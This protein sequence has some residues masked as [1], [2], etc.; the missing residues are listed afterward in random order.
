MSKLE[1]LT[2]N[3]AVAKGA[4]TA[5]CT[6]YSG[7]PITPSSEIA[8]EM[9]RLLPRVNGK[10]IQMEDEIAGMGAAIGASLTGAK[11]MTATS[12]PGFS[13]KQENLGFAIMTEIPVVIVNVMRGGPSTGMPTY[14]SQADVMQAKWGTHGDHEIIALCPS[15]VVESFEYTVK[16]FNLAE[17]YRTP[18]VLLIDE[19]IAHMSEKV[20][21]FNPS[22][23]RIKNRIKV[24][25]RP[26]KYKPYDTKFGDVPPLA[27]YGEGYRYHITG[28]THDQTGFPSMNAKIVRDLQERLIDKIQNKMKYFSYYEER[29]TE[30]AEVI[31]IAYGSVARSAMRAIKD[32]RKRGIK[33]GLYRPITI[34]PFNQKRI[35]RYA[36]K[37]N[38]FLVPEMN[39]GQLVHE[40]RSSL[41]GK[42]TK[43]HTLNK[44]D[45]ELITPSEILVKL[46][47]VMHV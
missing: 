29:M 19:I 28:L 13:L 3:E 1:L 45:G 43:I 27:P 39:M 26:E 23:Y 42:D 38:H 6:F 34:W 22:H 12:G 41:H 2:G 31:I 10:F 21:M 16:A 46:M 9:S 14:P 4:I 25:E 33:A 24:S 17:Q 15:T 36:K 40:V 20:E 5:G 30:D 35:K 44:A 7:Y 32:A 8:E 11:T 47:E 18:V 37:C